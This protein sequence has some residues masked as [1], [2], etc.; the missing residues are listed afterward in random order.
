MKGFDIDLF[1][2]TEGFVGLGED[3][4]WGYLKMNEG[5]MMDF[6]INVLLS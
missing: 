2:I 4:H 6:V 1:A 3:F 5:E